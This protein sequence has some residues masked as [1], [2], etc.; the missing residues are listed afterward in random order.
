MKKQELKITTAMKKVFAVSLLVCTL[1]SQVSAQIKILS[2]GKVGVRNSNPTYDLDAHVSTVRFQNWTN[3]M[4]DWSGLCG[5][6]VIYPTMNW[7][8]Q[9]GKGNQRVG[10]IFTYGIHSSNYWWDSDDSIKTE[11]SPISNALSVIQNMNGKEYY[12]RESFID[13]IPDSMGIRADF[14]RKHFGF[15]A[16]ELLTVLP[17]IVK[18]D[19]FSDRYFVDYTAVI[20]FLTEAIKEQQGTITALNTTVTTQQTAIEQLQ[21]DVN[22]WIS[23]ISELQSDITNINEV[24]SI[25]CSGIPPTEGFRGEHKNDSL[26]KAAP[27]KEAKASSVLLYQNNPNPFDSKTE[28]KYYLPSAVSSVVIIVS[29]LT[30]AQVTSYKN[31]ATINGNHSITIDGGMLSAGSYYYT[32]LV[33]GKEISTKKNDIG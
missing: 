21:N 1:T 11:V 33:N 13:S 14:T 4:L 3:V 23:Q 22:Y 27:Y 20:P 15:M 19:S 5:S 24:L 25:C 7:Y 12:F 26:E 9:L 16:R 6:P 10:N 17:E 28:I 18:H 8:L 29:N 2:N 31:L 32:L 30:G